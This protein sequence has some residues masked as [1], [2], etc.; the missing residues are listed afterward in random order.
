MKWESAYRYL[1]TILKD[2]KKKRSEFG[3]NSITHANRILFLL[4]LKSDFNS[5]VKDD[6]PTHLK[7]L[8]VWEV[9]FALNL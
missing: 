3:Q 2:V 8:S 1:K 4:G 9:H 7:N 6:Q 5:V